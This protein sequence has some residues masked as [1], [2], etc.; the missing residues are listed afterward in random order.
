MR[1]SGS[2]PHSNGEDFSKFFVIFLEIS[3]L[4]IKR[5]VGINASKTLNIQI[6]KIVY[7]RIIKLNYLIGS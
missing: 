2:N 4:K 1:E 7:I 3:S 6:V 5:I